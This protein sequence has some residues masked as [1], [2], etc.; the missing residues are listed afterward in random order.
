MKYAK[1][2]DHPAVRMIVDVRPNNTTPVPVIQ[3]LGRVQRTDDENGKEYGV[4]LDPAG[5]ITRWYEEIERIW[6]HGVHE[7]SMGNESERKQRPKRDRKEL[8]CRGCKA[9]IPPL[10]P[11]CPAC[12]RERPKRR[13]SA[14]MENPGYMEE[15][16]AP[17]SRKWMMDREWVWKQLCLIALERSNGD[18][19]SAR[20]FAAG[21]WKDCYGAWP[22]WSRQ[23][24]APRGMEID[25][26]VRRKVLANVARYR[27][28]LRG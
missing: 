21:Q 20:G 11:F 25:A 28:G 24:M 23:F 9:I 22:P 17:G 6:L 26:R 18:A 7:L 15:V 8:Q 27:K 19:K 10:A 2:F 5:N 12:G 14:A 16:T 13:P 1:G 4:V 3:K